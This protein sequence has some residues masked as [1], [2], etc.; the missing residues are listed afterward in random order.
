MFDISKSCKAYCSSGEISAADAFAGDLCVSIGVFD[1]VHKG[2]RKVLSVLNAEG[3]KAHAKT[4]VLTFSRNPKDSFYAD[5]QM[6]IMD[7]KQK[8]DAIFSMGIDYVIVLCFTDEIKRMSG[9]DFLNGLF[10]KSVVRLVVG[11]DFKCGNPSHP[12]SVSGMLKEY[13]NRIVVVDD[14]V[15]DGR[16]ISSTLLRGII[17]DKGGLSDEDIRKYVV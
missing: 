7:E 9:R 5:A 1:G 4:A 16:K 11:R 17:R 10:E 15:C 14:V 6:E 8:S 2:H 13:K 12:M 3:E